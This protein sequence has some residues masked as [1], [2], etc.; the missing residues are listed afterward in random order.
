MAMVRGA[1]DQ[2]EGHRVGDPVLAQRRELHHLEPGRQDRRV[3]DRVVGGRLAVLQPVAAALGDA[4]GRSRGRRTGRAGPTACG[5][6][7]GSTTAAAGSRRPPR[8]TIA[9]RGQ[10]PHTAAQ[11]RP[12]ATDVVRLRRG[13]VG[14]LGRS[15]DESGASSSPSRSIDDHV[16]GSVRRGPA[17]RR[18]PAMPARTPTGGA[19]RR[20]W[21]RRWRPRP[22][23]TARPRPWPGSG[24]PRRTARP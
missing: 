1:E 2:V 20:R 12:R 4:G 3:A 23:R 10:L 22:A 7:R 24:W 14:G 15:P 16:G 13:P 18:Q 17:H 21:R 5:R 19:A 8:A 11:I 6:R 9:R